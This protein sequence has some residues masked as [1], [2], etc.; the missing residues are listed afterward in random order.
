MKKLELFDKVRVKATGTV[1]FIV[2]I[3][4]KNGHIVVEKDTDESD[5]KLIYEL[6]PEDLELVD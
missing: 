2:D 1:G 3:S 4:K 6:L 5:D